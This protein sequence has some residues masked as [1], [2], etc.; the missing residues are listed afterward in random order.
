MS[1]PKYPEY[2]ESGIDSL[3]AVPKSWSITR[4]DAVLSSSRRQI[5]LGQ[6]AE[7]EVFHYSIP[8]VQEFGTGLVERGAEIASA[9]QLIDK[10]VVLVSKLNP[11]KATT[12][13]AEPQ[14]KLT[15]CSTEFVCL[16]PRSVSIE[17]LA[18]LVQGEGFRQSLESKVMSVTN[19]HQRAEPS[20]IY[21]F[22]MALPPQPEQQN[23]SV[24]LDRETAKIDALV[25]EQ[26]KL[27][28]LLQEK[29]Q[30][31]I[32]HAV[33][34]GLDPYVPLK[35]SEVEWLGEVPR[36]WHIKRLKY[37]ITNCRNGI[38]GADPRDDENDIP[39]IRV[40]DFDRLLMRVHSENPTIRN[41]L[42]S[43]RHQRLL[44][45]GNLLLEKSGGGD[46]QPVGFVVLYDD[47][48]S[49]VCSN[50]IARVELAPGMSSGY[51]RYLHSTLYSAQVNTRSINQ[52]SGIQNLDQDRYFNELAPFP[53]PDEQKKIEE[54]I[55]LQTRKL[56]DLI[57]EANRVIALLR[58]RRSTL[59]SAA[60]IGQI[61]I[62]QLEAT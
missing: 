48:T 54:F 59:I 2:K 10:K 9:K 34:K 1:L 30:A 21:R 61:D 7:E 6:F 45:K 41:V 17:Y 38:W 32:S 13:I 29:R 8:S 3:G 15:L 4:S 31:V 28:E 40:A 11:R 37:S 58:E 20:D 22:W 23:I 42:P 16:E 19:S 5:D 27:I 36:H 26:E 14:G 47:T 18:Y 39:C 46:L 51:W 43:E 62:R 52:T 60:V 55:D 44:T 53:P 57:A 35:K 56:D 50:F 33:T 49:A 24:F 25:A 12:C